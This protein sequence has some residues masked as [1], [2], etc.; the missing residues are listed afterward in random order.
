MT[1]IPTEATHTACC[2]IVEVRQYTLKAGS[3][4]DF[5]ALF[6]RYFVESQ[7]SDG[8][9]VVGTFR[10]LDDPNRF[11][12]IRGFADMEARRIALTTFY[13]GP[14]WKAH[15]DIANSMLVENDNVLLLRP[16]RPRSG[17]SITITARPPVGSQA[18]RPGLMIATI[19]SL[20]TV[21][22]ATF[23]ELFEQ[24]IRPAITTAGARV[25]GTFETEHRP[26]TYPRLPIRE[27]AN[28]FA[29][30]SCFATQ[31]DY[32][33]YQAALASDARWANVRETFALLHIYSPPETWRLAATPRS[34]LHC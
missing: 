16:I 30:F 2:P 8:M 33:N 27:S 20:G 21:A 3:F 12:W 23:D 24:S 31:A 4:F 11:F 7:E 34:A 15:R 6:E 9:T 1:D 32:D 17:F 26:N 14:T 29:W 19:Y 5:I 13:E 18:E 10:V 28:V 22:G 25:L